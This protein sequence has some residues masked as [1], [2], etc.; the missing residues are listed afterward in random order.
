MQS[1]S[2]GFIFISL[3]QVEPSYHGASD[4]SLNFFKLWPSKNKSLI[5]ISKKKNDRNKIISIKKRNNLFGVFYN[6]LLI[7]FHS[8]K[9]LNNYKKSCNNRRCELGW[10]FIYFMCILKL[11]VRDCKIIYH[12]HNL[13]Y[14]VRKL[15]NSILIKFLTF[16]FEKYMYKYSIGTTVSN[17][18]QKF[19]KKSYG[20]KSILFENGV[21]EE[22]PKKLKINLVKNK[23]ILFSG[24]YTYWPNKIAVENI[25]KNKSIIKKN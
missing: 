20:S 22:V 8:K 13:E 16:Y 5:Q 10:I 17:K 4:I 19:V 2:I 11:A 25:F 6:L 9:K 15:K 12:A 1:N 7:S 18:D 3:F 23:Y 24:S 21:K 14:E